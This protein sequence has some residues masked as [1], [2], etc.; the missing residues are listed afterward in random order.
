M[1][2]LV[3]PHLSSGR[4]SGLG[5]KR[6]TGALLVGHSQLLR[7]QASTKKLLSRSDWY[8]AKL[9]RLALEQRSKLICSRRLLHCGRISLQVARVRRS[10]CLLPLHEK[11]TA[12]RKTPGGES[13]GGTGAGEFLACRA[14]RCAPG[15]CMHACAHVDHGVD[16]TCGAVK[17][18][19]RQTRSSNQKAHQSPEVCA[20]TRWGE[21]VRLKSYSTSF[22]DEHDESSS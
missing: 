17:H 3:I 5:S 14:G 19:A 22:S 4:F 12:S 7:T 1:H 10:S 6:R 18:A 2:L 21:T 11:A 13:N 9:A 15:R 20:L 16:G 8:R